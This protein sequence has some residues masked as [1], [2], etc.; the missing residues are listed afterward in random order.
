MKKKELDLDEIA[1][2]YDSLTDEYEKLSI[3]LIQAL[4]I[5]LND[6]K[7]AYL[8]INSRIKDKTSFIEKIERKN[9]ENPFDEI[10]DICGIRIICYYQTDVSK[11]AEIIS[12][13]F[14]VVENQD[15]EELLNDDQFGYR[16][17]HSIVRIKK[18]WL[19]AP[20]YRGLENLKAEIQVRTILM[21]AWAEIEHKLSY[22]SESQIPKQFR[23]KLFIMSAKLEEAD[24]QFENIKNAVIDYKESVKQITQNNEDNAIKNIDLNL[25]SLQIFLDLNFPNRTRDNESTAQLVDEFKKFNITLSDILTSY[26][27]VKPYLEEIENDLFPERKPHQGWAQTGIAREIMDLTNEYWRENRGIPE[28]Y[29]GFDRKWAK[30][31]SEKTKK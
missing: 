12:S 11:I 15:K 5:F 28:E 27:I 2:K 23:R 31:I 7:I 16:S 25:D 29:V 13:E 17:N 8:S 21:H 22:K 3:N 30:I 1:N 6:K 20:N 19:N 10:E 9:Y 4:E 26:E 14:T 18:G 24:E